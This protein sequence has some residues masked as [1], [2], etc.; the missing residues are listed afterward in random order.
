MATVKKTPVEKFRFTL[1]LSEGEA[2]EVLRALS[3]LSSDSADASF[4]RNELDR[5]LNGHR[6]NYSVG[7]RHWNIRAF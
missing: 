1:D 7:D 3:S 4:V 5:A 2:K 6:L